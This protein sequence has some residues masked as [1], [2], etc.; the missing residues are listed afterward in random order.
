[1]LDLSSGDRK[2]APGTPN[3]SF[4]VLSM[5]LGAHLLIDLKDLSLLVKVVDYLYQ[6]VLLLRGVTAKLNG[7]HFILYRGLLLQDT[8][9]GNAE[10]HTNFRFLLDIEV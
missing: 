4:S 3:A 5:R 1:M 9:L 2:Q 6:P 7:P 8:L 10:N